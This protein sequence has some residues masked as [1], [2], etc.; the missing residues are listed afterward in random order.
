MPNWCLNNLTVKHDDK[1]A[2]DRFVKAYNE[3]K[4]CNEFIPEPES[5]RENTNALDPQGW[6]AWRCNNWGTKWDVGADDK[7][8][9]DKA[10]VD[11]DT[12]QCNFSSAWAPPIGLYDKLVDLG[13]EVEATYFE[14]G[15]AFCGIWDNGVDDCIQYH[16]KDI[17]PKRI[18]DDFGLD[19]F[20][21]D[22]D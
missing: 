17:I 3:S 13:Y 1:N 21:T 15:M 8:H 5:V 10:V 14:P 9:G 18:W 20:F 2:L 16:S 12:A 7:G 4:V 6:Y 22:E 19:D 11:G